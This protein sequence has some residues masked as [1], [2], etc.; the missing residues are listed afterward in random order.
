MKGIDILGSKNETQTSSGYLKN[1]K[2]EFFGSFPNIFDS[3]LKEFFNHIASEDE[4]NINYLLLSR[5][6][7][8]LAKKFFSFFG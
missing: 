6:I 2:D 1:N 5:Q 7:L 4:K 8:I 3:D